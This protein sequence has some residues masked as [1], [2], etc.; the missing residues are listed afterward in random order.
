MNFDEKAENV[1]SNFPTQAVSGR[2]GQC[3][4]VGHYAGFYSK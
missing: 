2:A 1:R 4:T 3:S